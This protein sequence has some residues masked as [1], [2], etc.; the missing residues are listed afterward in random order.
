MEL[1]V[2]TVSNDGPARELPHDVD[3]E[4]ADRDAKP[5]SKHQRKKLENELK[6]QAAEEAA[7]DPGE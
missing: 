4:Q 1:P 3:A 5:L 6:K 7:R 2:A